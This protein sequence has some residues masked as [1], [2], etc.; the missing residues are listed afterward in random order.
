MLFAAFSQLFASFPELQRCVQVQ[1]ALF[2][3]ADHVDQLI[4]AFLIAQPTNV[5]SAIRVLSHRFLLYS[6]PSPPRLPPGCA[7]RCPPARR[8]PCAEPA[9]PP[10]PPHSRAPAWP[11][12]PASPAVPTSARSGRPPCR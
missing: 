3:R 11:T 6:P 9:N 8:R 10:G 1:A 4:T 7:A 12:V 2:Q 5:S